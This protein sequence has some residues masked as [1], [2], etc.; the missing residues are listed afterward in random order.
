[1][2]ILKE[3]YTNVDDALIDL[4][5]KG[6]LHVGNVVDLDGSNSFD[7]TIFLYSP[8]KDAPYI[9]LDYVFGSYSSSSEEDAI[10]EH[11]DRI[12]KALENNG[13]TLNRKTVFE[14]GDLTNGDVLEMRGYGKVYFCFDGSEGT[15]DSGELFWG[16]N[17]LKNFENEIGG[18]YYYSDVEKVLYNVFDDEEDWDN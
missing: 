1:M 11:A 9:M 7:L 5:N 17:S 10:I 2:G 6:Q 18:Y 16:S 13:V 4:Y 8:S 15:D 3:S 12:A 14:Q